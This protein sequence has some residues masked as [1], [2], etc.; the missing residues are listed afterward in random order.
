MS[1]TEII[2][3]H[4]KPELAQ[5][6]FQTIFTN[7]K[8]FDKAEGVLLRRYGHVLRHN[9][10]DVLHEYRANL[11]IEWDKIENF[12]AFFPGSSIF[13]DFVR[14]AM[15][16]A[17]QKPTPMLFESEGRRPGPEVS[18]GS[19]ILQILTGKAEHRADVSSA[20]GRYLEA[21]KHEKGNVREWSGWGVGPTEGS[22]AGVVGW[23]SVEV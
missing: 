10:T 16:L 6:A 4:F 7:T 18:T 20:W 2:F 5:K 9:G 14:V 1:I 11:W 22:F 21:L 19:G 15:P 17:S 23:E 13:Q 12:Q 8:A 3:F